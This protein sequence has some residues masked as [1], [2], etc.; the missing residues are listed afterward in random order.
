MLSN[1]CA[2]SVVVTLKWHVAHNLKISTKQHFVVIYDVEAIFSTQY[3]AV[4][5]TINLKNFIFVDIISAVNI[6]Y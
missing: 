4:F 2:D 5:I 3:I 1:V 6:K